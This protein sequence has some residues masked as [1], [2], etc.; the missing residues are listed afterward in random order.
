MQKS[1]AQYHSLVVSFIARRVD[2]RQLLLLRQTPQLGEQI[3]LRAKLFLVARAKFFPTGR[4]VAKPLA[5]LAARCDL[6]HP[7][8]DVCIGFLQSAR[9]QPIDQDPSAIMR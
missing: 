5:Q 3:A 4:V 1:L 6:L 9:P 2:E 7:L 8:C